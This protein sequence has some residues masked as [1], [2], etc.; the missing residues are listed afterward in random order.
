MAVREKI[1]VIGRVLAL[2]GGD[3]ER[4]LF[5]QA[6]QLDLGFGGDLDLH[7]A[8]AA[9]SRSGAD[10]AAKAGRV[11]PQFARADRL[12]ERAAGGWG[13]AFFFAGQEVGGLDQ[14]GADAVFQEVAHDVL[15]RRLALD[16]PFCFL[17]Q[18]CDL[19]VAGNKGVIL[20][21]G[22]VPLKIAR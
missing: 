2:A 3:Q 7:G 1:G 6:L 22:V 12:L 16:S 19:H 21:G 15:R 11:K 18:A 17:S 9:P 10:P 14:A 4:L 8:A 13:R 20:R 5:A